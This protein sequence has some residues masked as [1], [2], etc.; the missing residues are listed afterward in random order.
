MQVLR[1][2]LQLQIDDFG[3]EPKLRDLVRN[4]YRAITDYMLR[5]GHANVTHTVKGYHDFF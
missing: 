1:E 5:R 2:S 4:Y 3:A